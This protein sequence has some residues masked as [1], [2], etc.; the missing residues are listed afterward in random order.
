MNALRLQQHQREE[1]KVK[2]VCDNTMDPWEGLGVDIWTPPPK[3]G[4]AEKTQWK[5]KVDGMMKR[6][7]SMTVGGVSLRFKM[8]YYSILLA[9]C[10]MLSCA[11]DRSDVIL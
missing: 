10:F 8:R 2:V 3:A 11:L 9:S 7:K 1:V 6:I 5:G 4:M